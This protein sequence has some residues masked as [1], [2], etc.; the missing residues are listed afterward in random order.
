MKQYMKSVMTMALMLLFTSG[1]WAV[2][3]TIKKQL[4]GTATET[5]TAS[6]S[7]SEGVCTLTVTP[8][9]GSYVT[10]DF[11]TAYAVWN[12][13]LAQA[14]HRDPGV[15][16]NLIAVAASPS[17]T[18]PSG[19]TKYTFTVPTD[20]SD[21]EVTVNFQS[22][23]ALSLGMVTDIADQTY[24]GAELKPALTI[25]DGNNVLEENTDYTV[26]Y[27]NNVNVGTTA[28]ATITGK[29]VY[30]GS[31]EKTFT[32]S[33]ASIAD[34]NVTV[35]GTYTYTGAA[36]EPTIGNITVTLN[37]KDLT[38]GTDFEIQGYSNNT[39]AA[40]ANSENAPT[41]T[42]K[43]KGN[44]SGT[45]TQTF[46]IAA[47]D[48]ASATVTVD[49]TQT[50]TYTG[51]A[52]TPNVSS[53]SIKLTEGAEAA[54]NLTAGTDYTVTGYANNTNAATATSENAP[55][56]TITGQG[57]FT[58]TATGKFTIAQAD[59]SDAEI[60]DIDD[61]D[62]TGEAVTPEPQVSVVL[63]A[64]NAPTV[65]VKGQDFTYSYENNVAVSSETNTPKVIVTGTGNYKGSAQK[66]FNIVASYN[67]WVAGTLVTSNNAN[68]VL[69]GTEAT[70]SYDEETNTLTLNGATIE[71]EGEGYGIKYTGTDNFVISLNGT[72]NVVKG[73]ENCNAILYDGTGV[74]AP[75]LTFTN[76]GTAPCSLQLEAVGD[77]L[78]TIDGFAS[79]VNTGLYR[80]DD[81]ES[82]TKKTTI[83]SLGGGSGTAADPII[84]KTADDLKNF[85]KLVNNGTINTGAMYFGLAPE[86]GTLDCSGLS[87]SEYEPIGSGDYPFKGTFSGN[88]CTISNLIAYEGGLFGNIS[89]ATI[90][91]LNLS[92]CT[93]AGNDYCIAGLATDASNGS[94]IDNCTI[95][96][97]TIECLSNQ[98][99]PT[100]GG[101]VARLSDSGTTISNCVVNNTLIKAETTEGTS[102]I[103][104]GIIGEA[105]SGKIENCHIK[106]GSKITD[107]NNA[108][109]TLYAGAIVGKYTGTT[110]SGNDY[111][112][113]V[114]VET[115]KGTDAAVT[116]DGYTQRALGNGDDVSA[117]NGA[118]MYT[119]KVTFPTVTGA[120]IT[121]DGDYYS[122]DD[123]GINV[124]P[125]QTATMIVEPSEGN[126]I[127]SFTATNVEDADISS[128][129]LTENRTR[130]SFEMPDK[131]VTVTLV[132]KKNPELAYKQGETA[133]TTAE[134][135]L[136]KDDN[137]ALPVLQN[138]HNLAPVTYASDNTDVATVATDG[139]VTV[140]GIGTAVITATTAETDEY[141]VGK[142]SYTL[143]VKR[144]LDVSF[145]AS[146]EWA[147]Y[148]GTENLA[149]PEGLKAYQVTA[150]NGST[151][152]ISEIGYIPA[153]TAVL[154]N[155]VEGKA[156]SANIAASAYMGVLDPTMCEDNILQGGVAVD[157]SSITGGTVYVLYKDKF[158]RATGGTIPANRGYLVVEPS[159]VNAPELSITIGDH[160]T[161]I[162]TVGCDSVATD[163][164]EWYTLDG[165]KLQQAPTRKGL[166]IMNGKK[167][168]INK[169]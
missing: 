33:A 45:V 99:D 114:T 29:G 94:K 50:Y 147:T 66:T 51:S 91:D 69:G 32:I 121:K 133:V 143:T 64:G 135:I 36:I 79:V 37:D 163:N 154:L 1:A 61:Q 126:A 63:I 30:T 150:V 161:G 12:G 129:A 6:S 73:G 53:V 110:L 156:V 21:V 31:V 153:N 41:V 140:V 74:T 108:G 59:L 48:L 9:D 106:G 104:G 105:T 40:T 158:K 132:M 122:Y 28:K 109:A 166:Y 160:T 136:G 149:T 8:P 46:T 18:D 43:G 15:E 97:S 124:A 148:Y 75:T 157:V 93:F 72:N 152:T 146:N 68:N 34:A 78:T 17:N 27:S 44:Y 5:G 123:T 167:V 88:G 96:N 159:D 19:E 71:P 125:G 90:E 39:N 145:S 111:Y 54:T 103:A 77:D 3:V 52:I 118:V 13:N 102:G 7:I 116:K 138:P 92:N 107:Y 130:Y 20:G 58:G 62:Y 141:A 144:Q 139:T 128:E 49:P 24:T 87:E 70:V 137:T 11:I 162:G 60:A 89:G 83:T 101:I 55:I 25:K 26:E 134:W 117:D 168:V 76:G 57:N 38:A 35:S 23:K 16:D 42:I 98:Y 10:K 56:V 151:V 65:L 164:D 81:T 95:T 142:A 84:I 100:V 155:D 67:I 112:Y 2:D 115:R 22:R 4:D 127:S 165:Q 80:I 82:L 14:P 47:K 113:D 169:K 86:G 85:S 120:T 131:A 119:K